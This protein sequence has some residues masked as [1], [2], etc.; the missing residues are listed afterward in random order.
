MYLY[1]K[2]HDVTNLHYLGYTSATNPYT[3]TGSGKYWLRHLNKH[4]HSYNTTILL[5]SQCKNDIISTGIYFSKLFNVVASCEWANLK[6]ERGDGGWDY[7]NSNNSVYLQMR[8]QVGR[9]LGLANKGTVA[10]IDKNNKL[11]RVPSNDSRLHTGELRGHTLNKLAAVD[12]NG[13]TYHIHKNDPRLLSG[14]LRSNNAGK[15]YITDGV[16][17]RLV[18]PDAIIPNGWYIGDNRRKYNQGKIWIT[19]GTQSKMIHIVD[20]IPPNWRKGR[21]INK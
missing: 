16:A 12:H 15:I 6:E 20:G 18:Y 4:G 19:D 14:E 17:R 8:Q 2:T 7:I 11:F 10:V 13:T 3:Y 21:T 5:Y 9:Q 1:I